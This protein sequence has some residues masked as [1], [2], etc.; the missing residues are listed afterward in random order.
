[1]TILVFVLV[2]AGLALLLAWSVRR[3]SLT[4]TG[5]GV[6]FCLALGLQ[7]LGGFQFLVPLLAFFLS[8]TA[9]TRY[10]K[11]RKE[12]IEKRLHARTG[13][14]D[15][16]QVVANGG[17]ALLFALVHPWVP[18]PWGIVTVYTVFAACNSDTWAS[19]IGVFSARPPVSIVRR[20]VVEKG[21][22]GGVTP[23]GTAFALLGAGFVALFYGAMNLDD[24]RLG[25]H[26]AIVTGCG[27]LGSLVDS[28]LGDLVQAKYRSH[29]SGA[30]TEKPVEDGIANEQVAGIAWIDNDVVNFVSP[31]VAAGVAALLVTWG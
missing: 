15:W 11:E 23:L 29:K 4:R 10:R 28:V 17:P 27:L 24:P 22:S 31:L 9:I 5:A 20:V 12:T 14:R 7:I 30:L 25:F 18:E 13:T 8:S 2:A 21:L 3:H 1:M 6:A 26:L 19:E 16:V